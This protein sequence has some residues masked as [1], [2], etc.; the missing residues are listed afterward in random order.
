[1]EIVGRCKTTLKLSN[2]IFFAPEKIE[3][4]I[5]QIIQGS[6]FKISLDMV[7]YSLDNKVDD[8]PPLVAGESMSLEIATIVVDIIPINSIHWKNSN[9]AESSMKSIDLIYAVITLQENEAMLSS[10]ESLSLPSLSL[11]TSATRKFVNFIKANLLDTSTASSLL[12]RLFIIEPWDRRFTVENNLLTAS[13]KIARANVHA[14]YA[15]Q[16][17]QQYSQREASLNLMEE[18][19]VE[20]AFKDEYRWKSL[21]DVYHYI[22]SII[23]KI[24]TSTDFS[25]WNSTTDT[26][27]LDQIDCHLSELGIDSMKAIGMASELAQKL[28]LIA[29]Q[30]ELGDVVKSRYS[31]WQNEFYQ[32]ILLESMASLL[33]RFVRKLI[34]LNDQYSH[35]GEEIQHILAADAIHDSSKENVHSDNVNMML[36]DIHKLTD[37]AKQYWKETNQN[38]YHNDSPQK[39]WLFLTGATGFIGSQFLMQ[40]LTS[41]MPLRMLSATSSTDGFDTVVCLVR[42]NSL[43]HCQSRLVN[44]ICKYV[45]SSQYMYSSSRERKSLIFE[46]VEKL[47]TTAI[48]EQ[49]LI[50]LPGDLSL[51]YFGW[52]ST[53]KVYTNLVENVIA[54]AHIAAEVKML[55]SY[56]QV[57]R[58]NVLGTFHCLQLWIQHLAAHHSHQL[59]YF[60]LLYVS[61]ISAFIPLQFP[62]VSTSSSDQ[63]I[64][65]EKEYAKRLSGGYAQSKWVAERLLQHF[66]QQESQQQ[67][68]EGN[69]PPI[70]QNL[71]I[72][73]CGYIGWNISAITNIL[74]S[75]PHED[76]K[77]V[78][79]DM[80]SFKI[81]GFNGDDWLCQMILACQRDRIYPMVQQQLSN[82]PTLQLSI[83]PVNDLLEVFLHFLQYYEPI[84]SN[85]TRLYNIMSDHTLSLSHLFQEAV[86][87]IEIPQFSQKQEHQ[88]LSVGDWVY[89][90]IRN[91]TNEISHP[92]NPLL[93]LLQLNGKHVFDYMISSESVT[94]PATIH[95]HVPTWK[96]QLIQRQQA[97]GIWDEEYIR[98]RIVASMGEVFGPVF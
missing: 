71:Y 17:L 44:S 35:L 2:G 12:P 13:G 28:Q 4:E 26:S 10:S 72:L 76:K 25:A 89:H 16:V 95:I 94:N 30:A 8:H 39:R 15:S 90:M 65:W 92:L 57:R 86:H 37:Q 75:S 85:E 32:A 19:T 82:K 91:A 55:A 69:I 43:S 48:V 49:R 33:Q 98:E 62:P 83:L 34:E 20:T 56:Q 7:L 66:F 9:L 70:T 3:N 84:E 59:S 38:T 6:S 80:N 45:Y 23:M 61:S 93:P 78:V 68:E 27:H 77:T 14:H 58:A 97:R 1:L 50:I 22:V 87:L 42:G 52:N 46:W 81:S 63:I 74:E 41:S 21:S 51:P 24:D 79:S 47:I 96:D 54:I 88:G 29:D 64:S 40:L 5:M 31:Q 11:S 53:N 73:R 60:P 18:N 36:E 67:Q